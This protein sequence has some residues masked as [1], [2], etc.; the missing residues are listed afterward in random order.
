[1]NRHPSLAPAS[2]AIADHAAIHALLNCLIK[3]FA[4]PLSLLDADW[5]MQPL[6]LPFQIYRRLQSSQAAPFMIRM[7]DG[8]QFLVLTDR[9]DTLGSQWYLSGV[10]CKLPGGR[11]QLFTPELLAETMLETCARI[12]QQR[13]PELLVQILASLGLK[14][15]VVA[16]FGEKPVRPLADYL[17]SEQCLWYG[18][19]SQAAPKARLWPASMRPEEFSPEFGASLRLHLFEVPVDGLWIGANGLS[20]GQ[21]LSAFADQADARPGRAIISMHPIQA[22]LFRADPRVRRLLEARRI[23]ELGR[24]GFIAH[25]T[26]SVRTLYVP[27]HEYFIKGSLNIRITNCVRKNAW[28]ELESA[29]IIDRL[30]RHLASMHAES[31]GGLHTVAEP[32]AVSWSPPDH[33]EADRTWFREQTGAILRRNFCL[34]EVERNC[35]MAGTLFGRDLSL[36]PNVLPFLAHHL[37]RIPAAD[38]LEQWFG[39]YAR[40]LL[41]PV[42]NMFFHHGVVFEPH[43]QNTVLV[44]RNGQPAKLLLRDYEGVKLTAEHGIQMVPEGTHAR[45]RQS[46]EYPREQGW[47]RIAYCLFVNNL[48]EAILALTHGRPQLAPTMWQSVRREL[49]DIRSA[50]RSPAPELDELLQGGPIPCKTNFRIR[51]AAAADRAAGYVQ[52]DAPWKERQS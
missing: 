22:E 4:L 31:T 33:S 23:R 29:L 48:S 46:M 30:L 28:Y 13:N 39:R 34:D 12:T 2:R 19:P 3:E 26:A 15:D 7:P 17:R 36:Q 9:K 32:A 51:L 41:R 24:R 27:G 42:L 44:H 25:P 35:L 20:E 10:F 37:G 43:L 47:N 49:E 11:W 45:V 14:R 8:T 18:H 1:M 38:D 5:R 6:G 50:L 21:V 52:L 16:Y 40:L